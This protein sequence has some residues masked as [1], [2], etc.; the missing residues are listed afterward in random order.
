MA[1]EREASRGLSRLQ[2]TR[3]LDLPDNAPSASIER[4]GQRLLAVLRRRSSEGT[5]GD[6][7]LDSEI[8]SLASALDRYAGGSAARA[9][10]K[11][12]RDRTTMIG[13]LLGA[14]AMLALLIFHAGQDE[15][16]VRDERIRGLYQP[17]RVVLLGSLPGAVLQVLDADRQNVLAESPADGAVI[18]LRRGRY[19]LE[20]SKQGCS[21]RWTRSVF[22]EAGSTHQFAPELCSGHGRLRLESNVSEA[23]LLI[24]GVEVGPTNEPTHRLPSGEHEIRIEKTG[25][26]PFESTVKVRADKTVELRADLIPESPSES[27]ARQRFAFDFASPVLGDGPPAEP[28]PFDLGDLREAIAPGPSTGPVTDLLESGRAG[29]ADGGSTAWHDRVSRQMLARFDTDRSGEIDRLEESDG[30]SC[31]YWKELEA[32]F[33]LGGLGLSMARYYGFDGS[34]WHPGALGFSRR[35]RSAAYDRMRSCGLQA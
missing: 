32:S 12:L 21:E 22:F 8:A 27:E 20:V 18:E 25:Y 2:L 35:V 28:E 14:I 3:I 13:G 4:E 17:A 34:E 29:L 16:E 11:A 23:R 15:E 5:T 31:A 30:I 6:P 9:R 19:A 7:A 24:D 26:R 33:E 10:Q 1:Q